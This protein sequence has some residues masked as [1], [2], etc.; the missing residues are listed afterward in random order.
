M[1]DNFRQALKT[2][3][4]NDYYWRE[5]PENAAY[6][7]RVGSLSGGFDDETCEVHT[8]Q[9]DYVGN[10]K[11]WSSV[12]TK[13]ETDIGDGNRANPS[14]LNGRRFILADGAADV[15]LES[16]TLLEDTDKNLQFIRVS[17]TVRF[18][19]AYQPTNNN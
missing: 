10:G 16:Q 9:L 18:Y 8:L 2:F 3:L 5:A 17:F 12:Y 11:Q 13:I 14:G 19:R 1:I 4:G 15:Y 7:Y 6:P